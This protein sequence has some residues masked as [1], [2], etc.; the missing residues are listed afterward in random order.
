ME[1]HV[2]VVDDDAAIRTSLARAL[3]K[4]GFRVSGYASARAF[5]D[6]ATP[7]LRGCVILDYGMP[8]LDGLALQQELLARGITLPIIFVTGHGG[9][10][11]SVRAIKAGAL[12]FLEKPFRQTVLL[13]RL[14]MAFAQLFA[15]PPVATAALSH[16]RFNV[17]TARERE[18]AD[19]MVAHPALA[20][21]KDV[22]ARLGISP[23][24]VD[25]HR[26]RILEKLRL[27]SVAELVSTALVAEVQGG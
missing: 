12:D 24:T 26:A 10:P 27:R 1:R 19:F 14:E 3:Q 15:A 7:A 11:E 21:S 20:S 9:V 8:E 17:L 4:R 23:R 5:L 2:F 18:I 16:D 6:I 25:H 22:A 13:E